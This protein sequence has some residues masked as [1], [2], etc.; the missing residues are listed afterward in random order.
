[1]I[2]SAAL[3]TRR[4]AGLPDRLARGLAALALLV[5]PHAALVPSPVRERDRVRDRVC[6]NEAQSGRA[7][8]VRST[9]RPLVPHP[10]PLPHG[11]GGDG[12]AV[13]FG[14]AALSNRSRAM[15]TGSRAST[16]SSRGGSTAP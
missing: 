7:A 2:R 3:L 12:A 6:P 14:A 13:A 5:V 4:A 16:P 15:G 1:M 9:E 11:R 8:M 10:N